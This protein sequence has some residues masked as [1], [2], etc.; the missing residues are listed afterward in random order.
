[1]QLSVAHPVIETWEVV[2]CTRADCLADLPP[3]AEDKGE[4]IPCSPGQ[5]GV[6]EG[7]LMYPF[8]TVSLCSLCGHG[9]GWRG[10]QVVG[11]THH[12]PRRGF[13]G[14]DLVLVPPA[15]FEPSTR[16]SILS[17]ILFSKHLLSTCCV[18]A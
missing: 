2:C 3:S 15:S 13:G 10:G 18:C 1:M 5:A 6:S 17:P 12:V 8:G 11:V 16:S 7:V 9:A 14:A 4:P